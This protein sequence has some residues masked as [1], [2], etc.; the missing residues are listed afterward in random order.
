MDF[1]LATNLA[2]AALAGLAVG[3]ERE[4]SGHTRGPDARFAGVRTFALLGGLAG[5]VGHLLALGY[6]AVATSLLA[7][8]AALIVAAYVI[9]VKRPEATTDGTTEAAALVVLAI[10]ILAGLGELAIASAITALT[11]FALSEKS[12]VQRWLARVNEAEMRGALQFAVLALVVLPLLPGGSYGPYG[13]VRPRELWIVVLLFS[14]L[15]FL[16]YIARRVVGSERGYGVTGLLGGLVSSTAVTLHFSRTSRAE[17]AYASALGLGVVAACTV[18]VPRVVIVSS[19]LDRAV[20]GTVIPYLLPPFLVGASVVAL[21]LWRARRRGPDNPRE[22]GTHP[23]PEPAESKNPLGLWRSIQM[24]VSFQVVLLL[25]AWMQ[26][27]VGSPGVLATAFVL[28]LTDVD[29]LTLSMSRLGANPDQRALAAMAIAVGVLANTLL[30]LTLTLVLGS[31]AFR[32]RA[33]VGL[34]ALALASGAGL[35]LGTML[36][37]L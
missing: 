8:A 31:P 5:V 25:L 36:D 13:A 6:V 30:K 32:R 27:S 14:G 20:G 12:R 4:W 29:A 2:V 23:L 26:E 1:T 9:A 33:S 18:L 10:G 28:G 15:N 17:P 3:V 11:L 19:L 34:A 7:A 22:T 35:A 16:G 21:V 37:G 24:A